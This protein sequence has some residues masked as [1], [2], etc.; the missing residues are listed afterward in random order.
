MGLDYNL[1]WSVVGQETELGG[2]GP[3]PAHRARQ[4]Q[5]QLG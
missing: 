4:P 2:R 1:G 3:A 5:S